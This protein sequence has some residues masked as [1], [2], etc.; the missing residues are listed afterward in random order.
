MGFSRQEYWSG[1]PF[2]SP[3]NLPNPGIEPGSLALQADSLPTAL[4]GKPRKTL[5]DQLNTS[6]Y[7][8]INLSENRWYTE[9]I[10]H[11]SFIT[12]IQKWLYTY[13]WCLFSYWAFCMI[14]IFN[15]IEHV[16]SD[17][18]KT[19]FFHNITRSWP[20]CSLINYSEIPCRWEHLIGE[21][22]GKKFCKIYYMKTLW[23]NWPTHGNLIQEN[24]TQLKFYVQRCSSQ[25][26]LRMLKI[27][28]Q[29]KWLITEKWKHLCKYYLL[30]SSD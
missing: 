24:N 1:L 15:N 25:C 14:Y 28:K 4:P 29:T 18:K 26:Y 17:W 22:F 2:P 8:Q 6:L 7:S 10:I 13:I 30:Q 27:W 19:P 12:I 5:S 3:G 11:F 21:N 9:C 20:G 16:V 23:H